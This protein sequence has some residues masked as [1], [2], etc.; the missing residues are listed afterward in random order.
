MFEFDLIVG[1]RWATQPSKLIS[2]KD[3]AGRR[4]SS[5]VIEVHS[6]KVGLPN[7]ERSLKG[8]E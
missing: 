7:W 1:V 2:R 4:S 5:L 3:L 6:I 8:A